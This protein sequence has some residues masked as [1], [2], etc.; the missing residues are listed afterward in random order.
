MEFAERMKRFQKAWPDVERAIWVAP[1]AVITGDV[2]LEE[3][4]SVWPG[5]ILRADLQSIRIGE[6]SNLQDGVIVHLA[7]DYGVE[8][9]ARCSVGHRAILHA[10]AIGE[11]SLIGMGAI[12][13]DGAEIGPGSIVGAG[14]LVLQRFRC[15]PGSLVLGSPARVIRPLRPG[16]REGNR[17]LSEKYQRLA[18]AHAEDRR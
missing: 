1:D 10:C 9:G 6:G 17:A 7:D 12:V 3:G 11:E 14:A 2:R 16:E 4:T 15:P 13:M 18:R 8:V 5:A